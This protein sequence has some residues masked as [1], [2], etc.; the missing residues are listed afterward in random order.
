MSVREARFF[1]REKMGAAG[2]HLGF[3]DRRLQ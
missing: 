2:Q 1:S 3:A